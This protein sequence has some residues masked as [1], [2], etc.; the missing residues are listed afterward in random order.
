MKRKIKR[1]LASVLALLMLVS[2]L[3]A[4]ALA[5]EA[6]GDGALS[7]AETKAEAAGEAGAAPVELTELGVTI[8]GQYVQAVPVDEV[9]KAEGEDDEYAIAPMSLYPLDAQEYTLDLSS[10]W[11]DQLKSVQLSVIA[12][13]ATTTPS[14][15]GA[16]IT[17][18]T[19]AKV[20]WAV[21]NDYNDYDYIGV[22]DFQ[23]ADTD[24]A[25]DLTPEEPNDRYAYLH[26]IVGTADQFDTTNKRCLVRVQLPSDQDPLVVTQ[27]KTT[28]DKEITIA[29]Q[30]CNYV[31]DEDDSCWNLVI[32]ANRGTWTQGQ[33]AKLTLALPKLDKTSHTA[34]I[35]AGFYE[36]AEAA[37]KSGEDL[38]NQILGSGYLADYSDWSKKV[39]LTLVV[40]DTASGETVQVLPF[41]VRMQTA[42]KNIN[43][44]QLEKASEA[45]GYIDV[46]DGSDWNWDD[47]L[48]IIRLKPGNPADATYYLKLRFYDDNASGQQATVKA[49]YQGEYAS[50]AQATATGKTDIKDQLFANYSQP[51]YPVNLMNKTTFTI[52]DSEGDVHHESYRVKEAE[53]AIKP[54]K[55]L[56]SDTYFTVNG[57][58]KSAITPSSSSTS[59]NSY[60]MPWQHDSYYY[61]G[62]QTILLLDGA[63]PVADKAN[64]YPEFTTSGGAGG[65]YAEHKEA[66][67]KPTAALKQES[68]V[69]PKTFHHGEPIQYS[70]A[71]ED[72]T[73]LKNYWVTFLTQQNTPEL[74]VNGVTN[75]A[76]DHKDQ[77]TGLP[78]REIVLDKDHEYHHDIFL[79]NL[80]KDP[81]TGLT[82]SLEDPQ[83]IKLD[84]YWQV[85]GTKTL[86]GFTTTSQTEQAGELANVAKVRLIP[87]RDTHGEVI[88]GA[89]SGTL[90]ITPGSGQQSIKVKLTGRSAGRIAISTETV[91][92]GVKYVPYSCVIQTSNMYES[93]AVEFKVVEGTLPQGLTLKPNGEIYGVP[94]TFREAPWHI[95]VQATYTDPVSKATYSDQKEYDLTIRD[96]TNENVWG[97]TD[98]DYEISAAIINEDGTVSGSAP[99]GQNS[100]SAASQTFVSS[101]S[102]GYFVHKVYLDGEELTEGTDYTAEKG[103]TKITVRNQTLRSKG[104]GSHTFAVEFREGYS[105]QGTLKRAAQNYTIKTLGQSQ[106]GGSGNNGS[107]SSGNNGSGGNGGSGNGGSGGSRRPSRKPT[108]PT[109]P[110]TPTAPSGSTASPSFNDVPKTDIFFGDVEWAKQNHLMVGVSATSFSPKVPITQAMTVTVLA[111][112]AKI[113]LSQFGGGAIATIPTGKWYTN[114]AAWAAQAGLLPNNSSFQSEGALNRANMAIMLVKYLESLGVNVEKGEHPVQFADANKMSQ[115]ANNAFQVLYRYGVFRGVGNYYMDPE[116]KTTRAQFAA[117]I[118]RMSDSIIKEWNN[119]DA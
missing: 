78:V 51:G 107:G 98:A 38:T 41:V 118:H 32:D 112:M 40:Q 104:S 66:D 11:P 105:E 43:L 29:D 68:G 17:L 61:N 30:W 36:T 15:G 19:G 108:T 24:G 21:S 16:A 28:D 91:P 23:I 90:V 26:L 84:E 35:Y 48:Q 47:D 83:N 46:N 18:T 117:L 80:G 111:R 57:A 85:N 94:Q 92:E 55:P 79:A 102:F 87:A 42:S 75:A 109:S 63:N 103:S 53:T 97:A 44:Y 119:G 106:S 71:A 3:P 25:I 96:N 116:G 101:G 73:H 56:S 110:A 69:T 67:E 13:D 10:Y 77:A 14:T 113:D 114:A 6:A 115:E 100:W 50:E 34:K 89:I 9:G 54:E 2:L 88:G 74:F 60:I 82:V 76:E 7:L 33:K 27:A 81:M 31:S 62:Y 70:A 95:K 8:D 45:G 58:L 1:G 22:D 72:G 20:M 86:D 93:D 5:D 37:E 59:Y 39:K 99:V 12:R 49:A 52:I 65:V 4:A 64:I